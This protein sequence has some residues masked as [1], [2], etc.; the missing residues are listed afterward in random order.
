MT[1]LP[2]YITAHLETPF[3]WGSHDCVLFAIGWLEIS[4]G[5]D[6]L[7]QY[8]PW[9]TAKEALRTVDRLG[10]LEKMFSDNLEQIHP[11]MAQDGDITLIN[12]TTFLFSGAQVVSVGE[13]GL[14]FLN[15]MEAQCAWR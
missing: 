10:G 8:K 12:N 15:R 1:T 14:V 2:D 13:S 7:S 9:S 11:N 5:K 6:Y 3:G 4:K